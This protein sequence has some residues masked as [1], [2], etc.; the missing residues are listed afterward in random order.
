MHI[1]SAGAETLV[2]MV[3]G[4]ISD[5]ADITDILTLPASFEDLDITITNGSLMSIYAFD[6]DL[7]IVILSEQG[8]A[9]NC[10]AFLYNDLDS[11]ES[12]IELLT[13]AM[14]DRS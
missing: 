13:P 8:E 7:T 2:N 3:Y 12:A 10:S 4:T 6:Q 9:K 5:Y 11:Y 14:E 1:D